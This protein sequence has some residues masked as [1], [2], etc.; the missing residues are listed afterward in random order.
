MGHS[1]PKNAGIINHDSTIKL[2][3]TP[4][5]FLHSSDFFH[6][7]VKVWTL[8]T[9]PKLDP[10]IA[11]H[12]AIVPSATA[13]TRLAASAPKYAAPSESYKKQ[14]SI[15]GIILIIVGSNPLL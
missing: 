13:T 5:S 11:H 9:V 3:S 12:A 7:K 1:T 4:S 10:V 2:S 14:Q 15:M 8:A 6:Q